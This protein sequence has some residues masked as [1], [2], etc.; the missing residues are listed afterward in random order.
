[1][2]CYGEALTMLIFEC[3]RKLMDKLVQIV[4]VSNLFIHI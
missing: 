3:F 2:I 1:M 4:N